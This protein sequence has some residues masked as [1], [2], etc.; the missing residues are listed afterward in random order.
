M[1]LIAR[2]S[3]VPVYGVEG[4]PLSS[5]FDVHAFAHDENGTPL[6]AEAA[7]EIY[8]RQGVTTAVIAGGGKDRLRDLQEARRRG[9]LKFRIVTM[10][11]KSVPAGR[12]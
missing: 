4:V 1:R 10:T 3:G 5:V 8:L 9:L 11:S 12:L 2:T 6:G 7:V